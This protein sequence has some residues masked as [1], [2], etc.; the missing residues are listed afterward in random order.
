MSS[1]EENL[2]RIVRA[3]YMPDRVYFRLKRADEPTEVIDGREEVAGTV[4]VN[5]RGRPVLHYSRGLTRWRSISLSTDDLAARA[6]VLLGQG[7]ASILRDAAVLHPAPNAFARLSAL[8]SEA[9]RIARMNPAVLAHPEHRR[10][11]RCG[12][13]RGVA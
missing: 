5:Q 3:S 2:G 11:D 6:A 10:H 13:R 8:Q 4:T 9:L 7:L 1:G 12:S